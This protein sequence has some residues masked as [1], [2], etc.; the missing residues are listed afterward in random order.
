MRVPTFYNQIVRLLITYIDKKDG[1]E[2]QATGTGVACL[3]N[4]EIVILSAA[5]NAGK[6]DEEKDVM[7][8][9]KQVTMLIGNFQGVPGEEVPLTSVRIPKISEISQG[10]EVWTD[11]AIFYP[12][13]EGTNFEPVKIK[14]DHK[15]DPKTTFPVLEYLFCQPEQPKQA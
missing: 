1:K 14:K 12:N 8:Y 6:W 11:F 5:H 2:K 15:F 9:F 7:N 4:E 10:L 3:L 13:W